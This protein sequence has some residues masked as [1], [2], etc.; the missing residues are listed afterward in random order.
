MLKIKWYWKFAKKKNK[1]KNNFLNNLVQLDKYRY[2]Y[3]FELAYFAIQR[4]FLMF[5]K[6]VN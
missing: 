1:K 6:Y 4:N 2:G 3:G 5:F